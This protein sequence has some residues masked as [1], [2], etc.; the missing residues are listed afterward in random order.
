METQQSIEKPYTAE[1]DKAVHGELIDTTP[2]L[3][4][5]SEP[6][7]G[8]QESYNSDHQVDAL[9]EQAG[10]CGLFQ[11]IAFVAISF[12]MSAT[13]WFVYEIGYF[14]Q[15]PTSYVCTY[16]TDTPDPNICNVENICS[17]N[18]EIKSW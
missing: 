7:H 8:E 3:Q 11:V 13:S 9:F 1:Y 10:G 12:G 6:N 17:G 15:K 5:Q 2:M 16:T 14:I 4:D 18:P